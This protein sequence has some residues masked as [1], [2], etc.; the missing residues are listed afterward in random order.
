[1]SSPSDR[2][3]LIASATRR[4]SGRR[5]VNPPLERASTMLSDRA[6]LMRDDADGPVYGLDGMTAARELRAALAGLEGAEGAFIVPSG[7]A[8]V[9]VPVLALTR[10]GDEV[11]TTDAVYGPSRRFLSRY[12]AARGVTTRFLPADADAEAILAAVGDRTRL[13]LLESPASL[14]FQMVDV[15]AVAAGCRARGVMT[16]LDNTWAAGLAF[17]PLAHGVDVSVQALTKYVGGHSDLLMGGIA[18]NDPRCLSAIANAIEDMGWHVSP[19]DAW[20]ALRGLRTLPLRYA[21]QERS[22][23]KIARWLQAR[24]EVSR[25]LY[26]PLPGSVGHDLWARDFTGAASLMGVVMKGGNEAAGRRM[27]DALTLF[28]LGYSWGGF[29]SLA[30]HETHQMAYRDHPPALEG[31]LIRLH[32]GLEDP[33]D[34][35]ADLERG[36]AA[37]AG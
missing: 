5:P 29:E 18:A 36:L 24:P 27:L 9:T 23:L 33:D 21:E 31:E 37:F 1:M 3:R 20:L 10:P 11:V 15:A 22:G 19:D 12:Q 2:T 17:K 6:E 16:V 7:L 25:V 14:T 32:V 4:G 35:I 26:P 8:A 28:G 30:T 34:L 13:V